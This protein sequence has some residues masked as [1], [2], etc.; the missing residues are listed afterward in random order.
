MHVPRVSHKLSG[1]R[2]VLNQKTVPVRLFG[3]ETYELA[4]FSFDA[5]WS[6]GDSDKC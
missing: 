5:V 2:V 3:I 6:A 1:P 4:S